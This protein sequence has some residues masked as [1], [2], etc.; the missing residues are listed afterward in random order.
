MLRAEHMSARMSKITNDS[1]AR[2]FIAVL[3]WQLATVGVK[4]LSSLS[5]S[6]VQFESRIS[7]RSHKDSCC[8]GLLL[9]VVVGLTS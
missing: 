9:C 6:V 4:G 5:R 3:I 2:C 7:D 1:L 8:G